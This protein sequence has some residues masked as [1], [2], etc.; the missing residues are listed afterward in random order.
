MR[1][2]LIRVLPFR[3]IDLSDPFFDSLKADYREFS[4]W[5]A[6]KK[7]NL[8][9]V[10]FDDRG[11]VQAFLYLK[12][13]EGA[14]SD[15]EPSLPAKRRLKVGTFKVNPHGTRLGERFVKRL[16]DY[17]IVEGVLELYVT[18]F[19]KHTKLVSLF[20]EYGFTQAATKE[21]ANGTEIVLVRSL[22]REIGDALLD[23]PKVHSKGRGKYLLSIYPEFHTRL[24]PD[25]ILKTESYN[26][27]EDTAH[28]NS[29]HKIYI[30][31]MDVSSLRSGDILVIYRTSDGQGPAEY[32][33]VASSICVV[34]SLR[35]RKHF[36]SE[37]DFVKECRSYSVFSET[38]LRSYWKDFYRLF[39][40]KFT[41]NIALRK[42]LTRKRLCDEVGIDR[43]A[44]PSFLSLSDTQFNSI[45][46]LGGV[47]QSLIVD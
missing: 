40:I 38:E 22:E 37:D 13:E 46:H 19:E 47:P 21:T 3:E 30:C 43:N 24:L 34:E 5:F 17:A 12:V 6:R 9:H 41:Y 16:L 15:V 27:L 20:G 25:S 4:D 10:L 33:S 18:V 42:R 35:S 45:A 29:I 23:Y 7:D 1:E 14:V 8:A 2:G 26:V 39:V 44:R 28:T 11:G 32:R 31:K 36:L